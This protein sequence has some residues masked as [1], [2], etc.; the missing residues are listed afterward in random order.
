MDGRAFR[1]HK[2]RTMRTDAEADGVRQTTERDPRII[3]GGRWIRKLRIDEVPQFI[4]VLKGEMSVVGPRPER[5]EFIHQYEQKI[6]FYRE[7]LLVRPGI[8]G[9]AQVSAPYAATARETA[10]KLSYD[11]YYVKRVSL[12][13]DLLI[14]A[15]TLRVILRADRGR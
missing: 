10:T 2:L 12:L 15:K 13:L 5:A 4:N 3:P 6:P 1:L 7:R 14:L 9:W 8:T 11:L